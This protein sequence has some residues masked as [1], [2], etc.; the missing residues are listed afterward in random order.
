VTAPDLVA[1]F[2][3][4]EP[5][6]FW[7]TVRFNRLGG[8]DPTRKVT[9]SEALLTT[10]VQDGPATLRVRDTGTALDVEAWGPGAST[11]VD[12]AP[13]WLGLSDDPTALATDHPLIARLATTHAGLRLART[14]MVVETLVPIVLQQK[15]TFVEAARAW[16]I[17]CTDHGEPAPGPFDLRLAPTWRTLATLSPWTYRNAGVQRA[18]TATLRTIAE[19]AP[20][21][22]AVRDM[23]GDDAVARLRAFPGIGWWTAQMMLGY[24]LGHPDA[25]PVGDIHLPHA[26][27]YALAGEERATDERMLEL[28]Q[29]WR[30][31]RWRVL[32]LLFAEGISAPRR[33]PRL[34]PRPLPP[35]RR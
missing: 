20:R 31:Q 15:V 14:P 16:R 30:G 4:P 27:A 25:V 1:R 33:A 11:A 13:A 29:P 5:Y 32:R 23:P 22:E 12:R 17:L 24:G 26:V 9:H 28:L 3:R 19:H 6:G 8:N 10:R 2:P 34:A 35:G 18:Q 21:L 7:N